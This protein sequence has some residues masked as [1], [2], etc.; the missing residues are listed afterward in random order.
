MIDN[1]PIL[2]NVNIKIKFNFNHIN[3][4][5]LFHKGAGQLGLF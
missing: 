5:E 1:I 3:N 4:R 2:M